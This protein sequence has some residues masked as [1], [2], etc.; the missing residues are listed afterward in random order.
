VEAEIAQHE[1]A[2][3]Q[4]NGGSAIPSQVATARPCARWKPSEAGQ[5]RGCA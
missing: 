2:L 4:L 5:V 3:E 1:S